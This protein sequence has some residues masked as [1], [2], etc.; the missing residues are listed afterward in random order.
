MTEIQ[1]SS[2]TN[3]QFSTKCSALI[4]AAT[5]LPSLEELEG[6]GA[7]ARTGALTRFGE[8]F[9]FNGKT[10]EW[11]AGAQELPIEQG[12]L[13]VAIVPEML[14]GHILW[15]DGEPADQSWLPA[16]KF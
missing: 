7:Y 1:H 9:K 8:L 14:G 13:L 5:R 15:K 16:F 12:R 6:L 10:G 4:P 2:D 3:A 11:S